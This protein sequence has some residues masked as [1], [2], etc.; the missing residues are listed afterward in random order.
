MK[1]RS[2]IK[3]IG[4]ATGGLI[5]LPYACAER[6]VALFSNL[7]NVKNNEK[8]L[9]GSLSNYIL[10]EDPVNFS[11]PEPRQQFVLTMI[12]DCSNESEIDLFT[13][14]LN[15]FQEDIRSKKN[16][17]FLALNAPEQEEMIKLYF[18]SK[19]LINDFLGLIK[20]Y[21][22]LH[23]ETSENYLTTYLKYEFMPGRYL[24]Q[25]SIT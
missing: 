10:P 7:Q 11:T 16:K 17:H 20:K 15:A 18:E 22:L 19:S 12:N 4:V 5:I 2:A 24:G 9:I 21:S 6:E 25:I 14:G 8:L 1:R 13:R 23:F 3:H